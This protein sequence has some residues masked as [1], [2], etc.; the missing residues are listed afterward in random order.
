MIFS[1]AKLYSLNSPTV[2]RCNHIY[3]PTRL[4]WK[5]CSITWILP[6]SGHFFKAWSANWKRIS[7]ICT[8]R[9]WFMLELNAP[10]RRN[11]E[12]RVPVLTL[13]PTTPFFFI[14][15]PNRPKQTCHALLSSCNNHIL[16]YILRAA[17]T[18]M[19]TWLNITVVIKHHIN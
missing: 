10:R 2:F 17:W 12:D 9:K 11:T 8:H 6:C 5:C 16:S 3:R 19:K 4:T 7:T 1:M 13:S 15:S 14:W 18:W